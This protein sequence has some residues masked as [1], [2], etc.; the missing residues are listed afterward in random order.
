ML[1]TQ[2]YVQQ[3]IE[4]TISGAKIELMNGTKLPRFWTDGR[5]FT[6]LSR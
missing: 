6:F 5:P 3:I 2:R 4:T 1:F